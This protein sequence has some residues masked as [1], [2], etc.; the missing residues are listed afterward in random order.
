MTS[1]PLKIIKTKEPWCEYT[2]EDGTVLRFRVT[3]HNI[4]RNEGKFAPNGDPE[5]SFNNQM[6][7]EVVA[8]QHL[9]SVEAAK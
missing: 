6:Q 4:R 7:C 1:Q 5:Y 3:V 8:P 9:R 2:L